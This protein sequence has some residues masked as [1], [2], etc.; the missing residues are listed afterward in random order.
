MCRLLSIASSEPTEFRIV[1]REAPRSLAALSQEHRDGWGLAIFDGDEGWRLHKG[2]DCAHEDARF[3]ELAMGS[4]G[5]LLVAHVRQ[6]TVGP[7]SLSNTHPF[8]RDGWVFAHNGTVKDTAFLRE[9]ISPERMHE[10]QGDTDS[11][12]VF[13]FVLS[14]F[15]REA[16]THQPASPH[17]DLVVSSLARRMRERNDF[18]S[19][20]FLLSNGARTY[21]HRFGR[22]LFL[23]ERRPN[24]VVR[25]ERPTSTGAVVRTPWS[26]RRQ[27]LFIASERLTDEPWQEVAD[28]SLLCVDRDPAPHW[29][30]LG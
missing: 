14:Q 5:Q 4:R 16:I 8:Q 21:A 24:D 1:L 19:V 2:T 25:H 15:D 6:K 23:L 28:G 12:L 18:G 17:T 27:A 30:L 20:N 29:R 13:A 11:E 22:S 9:H 3:H 26:Q 7:T 10:I